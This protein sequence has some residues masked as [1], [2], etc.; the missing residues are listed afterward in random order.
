MAGLSFDG[1]SCFFLQILHIYHVL[2]NRVLSYPVHHEK[3]GDILENVCRDVKISIP[4]EVFLTIKGDL[5]S[6]DISAV[7]CCGSEVCDLDK[8]T[9][10]WRNSVIS[11]CIGPTV[12]TLYTH[13]IDEHACKR[14]LHF[15]G[16]L[17]IYAWFTL[18]STSSD[19]HLV[20]SSHVIR[21]IDIHQLSNV[22][23]AG[24]ISVIVPCYIL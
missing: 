7:L 13:F 1:V 14:Q 5:L 16:K 9:F 20:F 11:H 19:C 6:D 4:Q 15:L 3:L 24:M 8:V 23:H 22:M 10:Y 17:C 12:F 2:D 21:T 18:C